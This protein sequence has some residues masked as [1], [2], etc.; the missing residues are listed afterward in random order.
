MGECIQTNVYSRSLYI[1]RSMYEGTIYRGMYTG[2]VFIGKS[3]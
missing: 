1:G 2:G 3:I